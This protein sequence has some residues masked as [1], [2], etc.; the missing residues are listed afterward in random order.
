LKDSSVQL[1]FEHILTRVRRPARLIGGEVGATRGFGSDPGEF[2]VV[3]GFPDTYDIG[4][5]NQA[6]QILYHVAR[7]AEAVAVERTY[8]PWVDVIAEMRRE[9]IPLLT[10]ETWSPVGE[11]DL[12]GIT[13]QHEFASTNLLEMLALSDIPLHAG[14]RA[15]EHPLVLAGGPACANFSPVSRFLD[16]VVV[17]DGEEV[18]A[19]ILDALVRAK[20]EEVGREESKLRLG[21]IKGV[22]VPGV[23]DRVTRRSVARLAEAPYPEAGLVPLTGGVH[24]RAW[25]EV[26][27]GCTRGCRFCQAGMWYRPVRE[28]PPEQVVAMTM[29]QLD[30]TGYQEVALAS[31]STTDYS[32]L[33]KVLAGLAQTDKDLRVSLPSLRVDSAAVKLARVASPTGPSLTLAPEAG[34]QRMRDIINKNVTEDDI[35]GA[36]EEA[37]RAG[38]TTLKLYFMIGLPREGDDDV[39]AIAALCHK[40]R[41]LGRGVLGARANRLQINVSVNNFVPKPFTPFQASGMADRETL[42]RR[43]TLLRSQLHRRGVRAVFSDVERSYIEAVLARGDEALGE[44]IEDAWR[45][46][47]RFDSWT[48]EFRK[49]AWRAALEAAGHLLEREA[50]R[51]LGWDEAVPWDLVS[52]TVERGFLM[53]EWEKARRAETTPDCRWEGCIECGA[54]GGDLAL[55]LADGP[56]GDSCMGMRS[57]SV[58]GSTALP[59]SE[60]A[61]RLGQTAVREREG[62]G[63]RYVAEFSVVDRGR[64][65]GHL[66]RVEVFRRAVRRAGGR[67]ALS[68]GMRPKALL[69]LALPLAVGLEGREELAEFELVQEAGP[70]FA[71]RLARARPEHTRLISLE[72]YGS[73]RS[74]A[75]RVVGASYEVVARIASDKPD[76]PG[77]LEYAA[78][79]FLHSARLVIEEQRDGRLRKVDLKKY[80][81]SVLIRPVDDSFF[82]LSFHV[83]VS[84]AGTVRPEQVV[85]VI[86]GLSGVRLEIDRATRTRIH[87]AEL[88]A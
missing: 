83:G 49:E 66:D 78:D 21:R 1:R 56:P 69:S 65:V 86:E 25:V 54:C 5:S 31:L 19:E 11:A 68:T 24:D 50:T 15:E 36:A 44:V 53:A 88:E 6:I 3:L 43:Q 64:F 76:P 77:A 48:E 10:L 40:I 80:I 7:Q 47:A 16:A 26:M 28:R 75:A 20:K 30:C 67:L 70:D 52:G 14:E 22:F 59:P 12:V 23:S 37:F 35:L 55:D 87:L 42:E 8:L 84:P 18:F 17:G 27:R 32:C 74:L 41:E 51:S 79:S 29:A 57:A 81:D 60:P 63:W 33:D 73:P 72:P 4:I 62:H 38:K 85:G 82:S 46:G 34:S 58:Y 13:L 39:L 71:S 2:R 9:E 45:R 61:P